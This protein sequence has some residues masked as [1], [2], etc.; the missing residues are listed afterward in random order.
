[1]NKEK[2]S[3]EEFLKKKTDDA[4]ELKEATWAGIEKELFPKPNKQFLWVKA[5]SFVAAIFILGLSLTT[6]KG[7]ALIQNIWDLFEEEKTVQFELE[8]QREINYAKL[9]ANQELDYVIYVD[10]SRYRLE[11]GE[12][13][14]RIVPEMELGPQYPEVSMEIEPVT[15]ST[16]DQEVERIR[17]SLTDRDFR[18]IKD[19][20][21][22]KP[23]D[24]SIVIASEA[25]AGEQQWD[26][27]MEKY[28][29]TESDNQ[30]LFVIKQKYFLEAEEGHGVRFDTMLESFEIVDE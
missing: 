15:G 7:Q 22:V 11:E 5:A 18:I 4:E 27:V 30:A 1:M 28:Y 13:S 9:N 26:S 6:H 21:I 16:A 19:S 17:Q 24:G 2:V 25:E 10:E 20:E 3:M 23:V 14:D 29:V 8:G 12:E